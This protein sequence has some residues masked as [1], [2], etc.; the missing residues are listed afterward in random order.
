MRP[1][2]VLQKVSSNLPCI[3]Y[4]YFSSLSVFGFLCIHGAQQYLGRLLSWQGGS[5][6]FVFISQDVLKTTSKIVKGLGRCVVR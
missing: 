5:V 3:L 6:L 1:H 2:L 4:P